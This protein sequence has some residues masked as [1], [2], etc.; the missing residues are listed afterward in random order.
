MKIHFFE[1]QLQ[2]TTPVAFLDITE[3][4]QS[5]VDQSR[6]QNGMVLVYS[7]HT[8]SAIRVNES[9]KNLMNDVNTFLEKLAPVEA[10][11]GHDR[12][13]VDGRKN[14][15]AHLHS[16]LLSSSET[17]PLREGKLSLGSWQ[18]LFFVELDGPRPLRKVIVEVLGE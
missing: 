18:R 15:H 2:T 9:E 13:P 7:Q 12:N 11:Y 16:W 6:V 5:M 17:L 3:R 10:G 14:A 8:T 4:V 1:I